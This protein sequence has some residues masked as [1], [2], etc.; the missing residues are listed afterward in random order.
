MAPSVLG[1]G[2]GVLFI[3]NESSEPQIS[4]ATL[5]NNDNQT[6][7]PVTS[8]SDIDFMPASNEGTAS[9]SVKV[10]L[11]VV[12]GAGGGFI[13]LFNYLDNSTLPNLSNTEFFESKLI[14]YG[15]SGIRVPSNIVAQLEWTTAN[16]GGDWRPLGFNNRKTGKLNLN[17]GT[18]NLSFSFFGRKVFPPTGAIEFVAGVE[19]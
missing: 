11:S 4:N 18:Y 13:T 5:Y 2:S 16:Q 9:G 17:Q 14:A 7:T 3:P 1:V 8:V 15:P 10:N 19:V 6:G 12:I